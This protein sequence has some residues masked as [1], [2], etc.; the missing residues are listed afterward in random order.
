M[1]EWLVHDIG[2]IS[3][4]GMLSRVI[5]TPSQLQ[6]NYSNYIQESL[7]LAYI[8]ASISVLFP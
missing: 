5:L 8:S 6:V 7:I 2:V 4:L 3:M 1:E